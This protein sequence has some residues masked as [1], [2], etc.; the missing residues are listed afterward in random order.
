MNQASLKAYLRSTMGQER[1]SGL[2]LMYIHRN[3][4]VDIKDII[5]NLP[6]VNQEDGVA[7]HFNR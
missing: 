1:L 3:L 4:D 2:A 5:G 6:G 7:R